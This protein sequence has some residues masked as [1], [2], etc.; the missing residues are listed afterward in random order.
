MCIQNNYLAVNANGE[1]GKTWRDLY[2]STLILLRHIVSFLFCFVLFSGTSGNNKNCNFIW[3]LQGLQNAIYLSY[4]TNLQPSEY[5]C[6]KSVGW[7]ELS[8]DRQLK[9]WK[10]NWNSFSHSRNPRTKIIHS[11]GT[12]S[13]LETQKWVWYKK[14]KHSTTKGRQYLYC[15]LAPKNQIDYWNHHSTCTQKLSPLQ[16]SKQAVA[17]NVRLAPIES[18]SRL[19]ASRSS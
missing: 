7:Y 12:V 10:R 16:D 5:C 9:C 15:A 18:K 11:R 1:N 14:K 17:E 3:R 13:F 19:S 6:W 2:C 4:R 8:L